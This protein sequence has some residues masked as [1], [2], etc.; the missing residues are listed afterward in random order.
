M[1][2]TPEEIDAMCSCARRIHPKNAEYLEERRL[3]HVKLM[4]SHRSL[5]VLPAFMEPVLRVIPTTFN[6][7]PNRAEPYGAYSL[8]PIT[9]QFHP[10]FLV[11]ND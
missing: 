6:P 11:Y 7:D 4:G 9:R 8:L 3:E 10:T 1:E 2:F 5:D